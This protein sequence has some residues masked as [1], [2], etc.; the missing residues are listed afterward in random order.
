MKPNFAL[1]LSFDG[2]GLLHRVPGGW[3]MVGDVALDAPDLA[4]ALSVLR[5]TAI[6]LDSAGLRSKLVIPN[7]QIRYLKLAAPAKGADVAAHVARAL[8]GATPYAVADLRFDWIVVGD[9]LH[10]AAVARETLDEA[11]AFAEEHEFSPVSFVAIPEADGFPG[12]PFFGLAEAADRLIAPGDRLLR[13]SY[14]IRVLGRADVSAPA[15]PVDDR[16]VPD[17]TES[18]HPAPVTDSLAAEESDTL[19]AAPEDEAPLPAFSS[20]RSRTDAAESPDDSPA[21]TAAPAPEAVQDDAPPSG[22][23]PIVAELPPLPDR[24]PAAPRITLSLG[25]SRRAP[26]LTAVAPGP[27][28]AGDG[29]SFAPQAPTPDPTLRPAAFRSVPADPAE[30]EEKPGYS[31]SALLARLGVSGTQTAASR[32]ARPEQ[33]RATRPDL[34]EKQRLTIFG[35]R[36]PEGDAHANRGKPR[37]LGLILTGV[38]LL[39]LATVAAW[40]SIFTE[41]GFKGLFAPRDSAVATMPDTPALQPA[42]RGTTAQDATVDLVRLEDD[43]TLSDLAEDLTG[44]DLTPSAAIADTGMDSATVDPLPDAGT[45]ATQPPSV[46]E[47]M[48]SYAATGIW[49]IAPAQPEVPPS[50]TVDDLYLASIDTRLQNF[51]AVA[52]PDARALSD[53]RPAAQSNPAA[54]G[55]TFDLDPRGLVIATPEGAETPDGVT[56]FAGRPPVTPEGMP[57]RFARTPGVDP[58]PDASQNPAPQLAG[59][60]PRPRPDT[61]VESNERAQ[62]GGLSRNELAELRPR[63][64]P[65]T[66]AAVALALREAAPLVD[67]DAD[68]AA[69]DEADALDSATEQAIASSLKPLAR[70]RNFSQTVET[71]REAAP[72]PQQQVASAATLS[73]PRSAAP[74]IPS[75][76][77]VA[78][79]ATVRGAINLRQVNLI[80]V[81]GQPSNRRALVRLSNGRYQK[82][83]VGDRLD[84]GQVRAIGENELS[85]VKGNR[86]IVLTMPRG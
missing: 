63:P 8:D 10:V 7:E 48:S 80:G 15:G 54:P 23:R 4:G 45:P 32:P 18:D 84:G 57:T 12:E 14:A 59:V 41:S 53:Q 33:P 36:K 42:D 81:Y 56:V 65:A 40:S 79:Q 25:D 55:T 74:Q 71:S 76:A 27:Q 19:S 70:P 68:E 60:R 21:P 24:L 86:A 3:H 16:A 49:L 37:F 43:Q 39:F 17:S 30:D 58:E 75:S 85:Y 78:Q 62:L 61:L 38:L 11:E 5:Q 73:A 69:E 29:A 34:S 6:R 44:P 47:A 22:P 82:V 52:L 35:A 1:T 77:S 46:D 9:D 51:D 67:A 31:L 28:D 13:D 20:R 50:G 26:P 83:Q 64:R 66:L 72:A 2:I